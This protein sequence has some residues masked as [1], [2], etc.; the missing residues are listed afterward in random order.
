MDSSRF[1]EISETLPDSLTTVK[2]LSSLALTP[3]LLYMLSRS[4]NTVVLIQFNWVCE[5]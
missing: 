2:Q 3:A 1:K 4:N 5:S